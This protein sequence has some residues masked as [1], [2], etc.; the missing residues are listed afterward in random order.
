ML[1]KS[2]FKKT[3]HSATQ[4]SYKIA[5]RFLLSWHSMDKLFPN[6]EKLYPIQPET[7]ATPEIKQMNVFKHYSQTDYYSLPEDIYTAHLSRV[8]YDPKYELLMTESGK[9]IEEIKSFIKMSC[10]VKP[11]F[12]L[13]FIQNKNLKITKLLPFVSEPEKISGVCSVIRITGVGVRQ[14]NYYHVLVDSLPRLYLLNQPEYQ[15]IDEIKLLFSSK[16]TTLERFY[17]KKLAPKN[18][19]ITVI[20]N[21]E[22]LYLIDKLIFPS[23]LSSADC[24][25][26]PSVYIEYFR[27][28][29]LPKRESK[30]VNLIF[31]SRIKASSRRLIN[32]DEIFESLSPYGFERYILEDLSIEAQIELFYDAEYV[33]GIHGAGLTN[34]LFSHQIKVLELFPS[35]FCE[36]HYYYLAKSL[37]HTYGYCHG[38]Y[39]ESENKFISRG[40]L[41]E[42]KRYIDFRVNVSEVV[43][44]LLELEKQHEQINC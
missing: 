37:G 42:S 18:V 1:P 5:R 24:G 25:Y 39:P 31:I 7:V 34:I 22:S 43:E 2:F 11:N 9:I 13:S 29:V 33:V 10:I 41:L 36:L 4:Y 21:P 26:L 30:K 16:P 15:N 8:I 27:D 20:D 12:I 6:I 44:R 32:E 35:E 14:K 3:Q 17:I 23:Y 19:Q 40:D 28:K 38:C